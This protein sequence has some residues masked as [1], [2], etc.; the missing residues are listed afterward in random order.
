MRNV[1][2]NPHS[3]IHTRYPLRLSASG[4]SALSIASHVRCVR[5]LSPLSLASYTPARSFYCG[6]PGSSPMVP[7]DAPVDGNVPAP[8]RHMRHSRSYRPLIPLPP[9]ALTRASHPRPRP[10]PRPHPRPRRRPGGRRACSEGRGRCGCDSRRIATTLYPSQAPPQAPP[11]LARIVARARGRLRALLHSSL[12]AARVHSSLSRFLSPLPPHALA[13][14]LPRS[15]SLTCPQRPL[16]VT[17]RRP[18]ARAP[19]LA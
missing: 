4:D 19:P 18:E 1:R 11:H 7:P 5:S 8:F 12:P 15:V 3:P 9:P 14:S 17:R 2:K 13:P 6:R 10:H 16:R